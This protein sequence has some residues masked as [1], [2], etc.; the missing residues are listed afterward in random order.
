MDEA[1]IV[2]RL[3]TARQE[4]LD[5]SSR[6]R[7]L[8]TPL[9][10]GRS[11]R[12]D[13]VD[14]LS[15]EVFARLMSKNGTFS[16]LPTEEPEEPADENAEA[17]EQSEAEEGSTP[18]VFAEFE[19]PSLPQP[20]DDSEAGPAARHTDDKLQTRL[21][22]EQLQKRLLRLYYD[23]RTYE[24][25]QGVNVL[26]L[27]LG[28]LK[29]TEDDKDSVVRYAP[30]VLVP[31]QLE[32]RSAKSR[33][34]LRYTGEDLQTNLSLQARLRDFGV[35]LPELP[36][37][38][39][40]FQPS[41]YY[42]QVSEAIVN[43]KQWT[44]LP[45]EMQ[46]GFFSF[47]TFLMYR[48]LAAEHWPDQ[49]P[50]Q[51][52]PLMLGLMG[53]G[54]DPDEP[55]PLC[56]EEDLIDKH[57]DP[58]GA[59]HVMDADAS[60][61][62][63]VEEA[64][65]GRNLVVQGPPG[66]GKSQTIT[67]LLAAAVRDGKKILFVSEKIA[68]LEVVRRRM[69]QVG[70]GELCLELHSKQARK[71]VILD[72]LKATRGLNAP[73]V[74]DATR[75][76][77]DLRQHR[78]RLNAHAE[79]IHEPI[80]QSGQS[81]YQAMG[82]LVRLTADGVAPPN[83]TLDNVLTWTPIDRER[84]ERLLTQLAD[85]IRQIGGTQTHAWRGVRAQ[86]ILPS[87]L[88][89]RMSEVPG[90]IEQLTKLDAL[91]TPMT[92]PLA[93]SPPETFAD[94]EAWTTRLKTLTSRPR[95]LDRT[96]LKHEAWREQFSA[97]EQT[98]QLGQQRSEAKAFLTPR[99]ADVA[100][101]AD[102]TEARQ[103][104]AAW[105]KS[106]FAWFIPSYWRARGVL[107]GLLKGP[108]P[109]S[110]DE[111]L[112]IFDQLIRVRQI[113]AQFTSQPWREE[114][115]RAAFGSRWRGVDSDFA[116]LS[117][118]VTWAQA[119]K[120]TG[121]PDAFLEVATNDETLAKLSSLAE[122]A[123]SLQPKLESDLTTFLATFDY[124]I[125]RAFGV[126]KLHAV[127]VPDLLAR[128]TAWHE[129]PEA[130]SHWSAYYASWSHLDDEGL[131]PLAERIDRGD[132]EADA[133]LPTFRYVYYDT[134]ARA[135]WQE[136]PKLAQ[137]HG[138]KH[139]EIVKRF[140][141]LDL[142]RIELA[143]REVAQ[144]HYNGLPRGSFTFGG[145]GVL[146]G[147]F[148][149]SRGHRP[150]RK[151][152]AD[153]GVA[154]Q[155]IKPIFMMSPISVAQY[156]EPGRLEF[157]ILVMDEASQ[158][159]PVDALGAAARCRQMVIVGDD[160]Q[161]PPTSFFHRIGAGE[162][163][164]V[165]EEL[166][167][168]DL[169]SVLGLCRAQRMPQRTLRGHYRSKH[170]SL[171]AV[172]NA[173]FYDDR[174]LVVPSPHVGGGDYGLQFV[175]IEEGEF[176]RGRSATNRTEAQAVAQAV[177]EHAEQRPNKSLGVGT[178]SVSQRDAILD[179]LEVLRRKH[180]EL[181]Q[182]INRADEEP[183]FVKN[184][185]TI[186]GDERDVIM[187]SIGY[188]RD[189]DGKLTMNFGPLNNEGGHRRLNVLI[190]RAREKMVVYSSI[191]AADIDTSRS[192]ARGVA[193]LKTFLSYA[194]TGE[195]NTLA[196]ATGKAESTFEKE[197][198]RAVEAAGYQIH[199]QVGLGGFRVDLGVVDPK[200]PS[201]Y[202]VGVLC[203]GPNYRDAQ[204]CRDRDRSRP[205]VLASRGW[206]LHR[207]WSSDWFRRPK[208]QADALLAV[209]RAQEAKSSD[210]DP[211]PS[212]P[213]PT[214][215]AVARRA[216]VRVAEA[217][218]S[219]QLESTPYEEA[220]F[221]IGRRS[222]IPKTPLSRLAKIVEKVVAI[223]GPIHMDEVIRRV[224]SL[225]G[226]RQVGRRIQDTIEQA[227]HL[228][229]E[230]G[231]LVPSGEFF[232]ISE[233]GEPVVR[234]RS[235]VRSAT[236]RQPEMLP[237]EEIRVALILIIEHGFGVTQD[238]ARGEVRRLLGLARMTE[239]LAEVIDEQIVNLRARGEIEER[240]GLFYRETHSESPTRGSGTGP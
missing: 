11:N 75:L 154:I 92:E 44:V 136:H 204:A 69:E 35:G 199:P 45:D 102:V 176:D 197:V 80:G 43:N 16:F 114:L 240:E 101:S 207:I 139:D 121:L 184:L 129:N 72:D 33:F 167:V 10:A 236:L 181:D 34:R 96:S 93:V 157:D 74:S 128:L 202:L 152:L 49:N 161:L 146:L 151:L 70:L 145:L 211:P 216:I 61:A 57:I 19:G 224:V 156:L 149:K 228:A 201:R 159:R 194:Q 65:L 230:Q 56:G 38:L 97:L 212:S 62:L 200:D 91:R 231:R 21:T 140:C 158:V 22:S 2:K 210:N 217:S 196:A 124:D 58:G 131:A 190:S 117:A 155:A 12:L 238:D 221:K 206:V 150:I 77:N 137:F 138:S 127:S 85:Q 234:D 177:L 185:E 23:A 187:I 88:S 27:A 83:F 81:L 98:V 173:E 17:E 132:V 165:E 205:G 14:E 90:L 1:E 78:D 227:L 86:S 237:P 125:P 3:A 105:G 233:A 171:I 195:L 144:T 179:E 208:E 95:T 111:Q 170:Q 148:E 100:W 59:I 5:L 198:A 60:Q 29:W 24:Q 178:F 120:S 66:T 73:Q 68:A 192:A 122:Q 52:R 183:F 118:I 180:S 218:D 186:Q 87:D 235:R 229:K 222:A 225:W 213:P 133:V 232:S 147:E 82:Q 41:Q 79:E 28:L 9:T 153:A 163:D 107:S 191:T 223:E 8:N 39:A 54:F 13:I 123:E 31:V 135:G 46:L 116:E 226:G 50:L 182:F 215:P 172:S 84:R 4:L 119:C 42:A 143:R 53:E 175:H 219:P 71:R 142:E 30:L 113:D 209:I 126:D 168:R 110:V 109:S 6:N 47:A 214:Q 112:A 103:S 239:K 76:V 36:D 203:D 26:F 15:D 115:G 32:R 169:E 40:D 48:D 99:V 160:Q 166:E 64:R 18:D 89:R 104:L 193:A 25:E 7:L 130:L 20:D 188:G 55:P 67:N 94:I 63:C 174:L 162:E 51:K 189:K 220:N 134:L 108:M 106:W 37:D 141:A 164:E